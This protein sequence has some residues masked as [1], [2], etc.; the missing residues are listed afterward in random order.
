[1]LRK[2]S[3]LL[4]I[5]LL[6]TLSQAAA[7]KN[8]TDKK[9]IQPVG[10]SI[11]TRQDTQQAQEKW[12]AEQE[13]LIAKYEQL[14]SEQS[15]LGEHHMQ[16]QEYVAAARSRVALKEKQLADIEQISSKIGPFCDDILQALDQLLAQDTPFLIQE[17]QRRVDSLK[18]LMGDPDVSTSEKYRKVMEALLIE[19]EYGFTIEVYQETIAIDGQTILADIFRLGR[20]SLF[21]QSL[22]QQQCGFYNP[23]QHQWQPLPPAF[24]SQIQS[25]V[26]M[27]AKRK[28]VELLALPLGRVVA[29]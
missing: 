5:A 9:I 4:T 16:L 20:I 29:Q 2:T 1:M 22:D 21:Y 15:R 17:R 7:E 24:N 27:A 26:D 18:Q 28:P 19:A 14:Q 10:Q 8:A 11:D 6:L 25:A 13:K 23:A 3:L 12:R